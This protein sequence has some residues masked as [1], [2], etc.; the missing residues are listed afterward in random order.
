[1]DESETQITLTFYKED[2]EILREK[3]V[4]EDKQDILDAVWECITTYMEL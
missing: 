2:L 3:F 1:M 4:I